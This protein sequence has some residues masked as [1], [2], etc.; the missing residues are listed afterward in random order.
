MKKKF[1]IFL[2]LYSILVA[3]N[4]KIGIG[5][6]FFLPAATHQINQTHQ[7]NTK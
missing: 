2:L 7:N 6:F 1:T 4:F 3:G 5:K